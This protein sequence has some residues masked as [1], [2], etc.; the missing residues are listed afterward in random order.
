MT[1]ATF[2][3]KPK[4]WWVLPVRKLGQYGSLV[5]NGNHMA[6]PCVYVCRSHQTSNKQMT[7]KQQVCEAKTSF[8]DKINAKQSHKLK[9][10]LYM[11]KMFCKLALLAWLALFIGLFRGDKISRIKCPP[12]IKSLAK[13]SGFT[14]CENRSQFITK[15][16]QPNSFGEMCYLEKIYK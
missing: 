1:Q 9:C 10:Q 13:L 8:S 11:L 12:E 6:A 16:F 15:W 3:W 5:A 2:C 14:V 4:S 7:N